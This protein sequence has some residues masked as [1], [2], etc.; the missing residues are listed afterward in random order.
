[1]YTPQVPLARTRVSSSSTFPETPNVEPGGL[2][3]SL[4]QMVHDHHHASLRLRDLTGKSIDQDKC[5]Q[6]GFQFFS[7]VELFI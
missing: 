5:N 4:L 7:K 6:L 2:E 3:A 1:M